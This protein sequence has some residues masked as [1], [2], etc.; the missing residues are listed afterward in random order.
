[1]VVSGIVI[2]LSI[3]F[4]VIGVPDSGVSVTETCVVSGLCSQTTDSFTSFVPVQLAVI[5]LLAGAT[6]AAGLVRKIT[7]LCWAGTILILGFCFVG[8]FSIGLLYLPL[9]IVLVGLLPAT[10]AAFKT[11]RS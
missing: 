5:P 1:M 6:V 10:T 7:A 4:A 9:A 2:V 8:L 11:N 3:F